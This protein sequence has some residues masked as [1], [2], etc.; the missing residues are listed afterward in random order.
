M[1]LVVDGVITNMDATYESNSGLDTVREL[2]VR[3]VI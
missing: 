2:S 3:P 1:Y